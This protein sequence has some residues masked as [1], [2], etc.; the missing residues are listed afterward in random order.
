MAAARG[1]TL[2]PVASP[3]LAADSRSNPLVWNTLAIAVVS[4]AIIA[5]LGLLIAVLTGA[6]HLG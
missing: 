5:V 6:I 1:R 2:A 4:L 3:A